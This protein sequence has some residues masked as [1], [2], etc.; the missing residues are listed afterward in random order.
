MPEHRSRL[1]GI[2]THWSVVRRAHQ[3]HDSDVYHAQQELLE[4]YG[5]AVRRYLIGA[6]G[7]VDAADDVFQEFAVRFVRGDYKSADPQRGRFR[8]FVKTAV[9][10]LIVDYYRQQKRMGHG[11]ELAALAAQHEHL[12]TTQ[13]DLDFDRSWREELLA[14]AW[15]DLEAYCVADRPYFRVLRTCAENPSLSGRE[16]VAVINQQTGHT[17]SAQNSRQILHRARLLFAESLLRAVEHSL[18][19]PTIDRL[20]D[21]LIALNLHDYCRFAL[22]K[23]RSAR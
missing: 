7:S 16:L 22:V 13:I 20:E 5:D 12:N 17:C 23:R 6:L 1:S 10:R 9:Y 8:S 15:S 11:D 2:D 3:G 21:E 14:K 4:Q 18:D 19:H